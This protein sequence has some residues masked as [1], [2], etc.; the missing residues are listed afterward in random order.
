MRA[1]LEKQKIEYEQK[2]KSLQDEIANLSK[3]SA[4]SEDKLRIKFLEA[5]NQIKKDFEQKIRDIKLNQQYELDKL[6][7]SSSSSSDELR[8]KF[9]KQIIDLNKIID[10]LRSEIE[11]NKKNFEGDIK[12][13]EEKLRKVIKIFSILFI[14]LFRN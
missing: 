4:S 12:S 6:K 2:I 5:E 9:E 8:I 11:G 10:G 7:Q 3:N 14:Y 13:K 1:E